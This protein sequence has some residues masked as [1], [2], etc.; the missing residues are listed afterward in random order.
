MSVCAWCESAAKVCAAQSEIAGV[1]RVGWGSYFQAAHDCANSIRRAC[2]HGSA[3][4]VAEVR[5]DHAEAPR[6]DDGAPAGFCGECGQGWP[7]DAIRLAD[8]LEGK[9][10]G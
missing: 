3:K 10:G 4:L 7:C 1:I 9:G 2:M 6:G 8:A 5:A